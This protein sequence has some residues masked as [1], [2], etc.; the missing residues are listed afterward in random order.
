VHLLRQLLILILAL[1]LL[2][3]SIC[4]ESYWDSY[5]LSN[6][7]NEGSI[8]PTETVLEWVVE[9]KM[10]QLDIFNYTHGIDPKS[11]SKCFHWQID[12]EEHI[13]QASEI[14]SASSSYED[15]MFKKIPIAPSNT[16][17]PP[18]RFTDFS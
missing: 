5:S 14:S 17:H 9:M 12:L 18:P 7:N 11:L 6:T 8:D 4:S 2:N 10:G 15:M 16:S 13:L 3:L 1:Q